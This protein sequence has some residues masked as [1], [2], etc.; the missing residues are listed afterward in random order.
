MMSTN[1][2]LVHFIMNPL[3]VVDELCQ[4]YETH[5]CQLDMPL[6]SGNWRVSF[7]TKVGRRGLS[8]VR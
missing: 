5:F 8:L 1:T 4:L 7:D 6:I 2:K 3:A